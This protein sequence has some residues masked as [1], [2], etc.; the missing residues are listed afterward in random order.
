[1]LPTPTPLP[2]DLQSLGMA[3]Q[4]DL[5]TATDLWDIAPNVL[6]L[7][8]QFGT[9]T[10]VLQWVLIAAL[11][12]GLVWALIQLVKRMTNRDMGEE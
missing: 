3:S 2:P 9:A 11:Y 7:W 12:A 4:V 6:Q 5:G 10:Q 1:M 8:G